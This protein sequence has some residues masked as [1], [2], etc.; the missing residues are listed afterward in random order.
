[1][2]GLKALSLYVELIQKYMEF[3]EGTAFRIEDFKNGNPAKIT[4]AEKDDKG[5][6]LKTYVLYGNTDEDIFTLKDENGNDV[7]QDYQKKLKL[8]DEE[9]EIQMLEFTKIIRKNREA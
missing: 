3:N 6:I 2:E 4:I 8:S 9:K 7:I 1:M 5:K